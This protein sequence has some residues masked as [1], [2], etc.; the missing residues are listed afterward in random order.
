VL[1]FCAHH[2]TEHRPALEAA[3]AVFYDESDRLETTAASAP[4]DER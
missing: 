3:G 1:L 4:L 2:A